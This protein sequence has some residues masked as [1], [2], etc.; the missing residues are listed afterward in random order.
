MRKE[1]MAA[2]LL[3][4]WNGAGESSSTGLTVA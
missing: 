2:G 3:P 1:L 4:F